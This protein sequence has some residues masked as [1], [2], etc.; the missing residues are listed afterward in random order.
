[1]N[2]NHSESDSWKNLRVI[3]T[4][5]LSKVTD[6]MVIKLD[7]TLANCITC[8]PCDCGIS[9]CQFMGKLVY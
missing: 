7:Y 8:V 1:M 2:Q 4:T 6:S 9:M 3:R 5:T